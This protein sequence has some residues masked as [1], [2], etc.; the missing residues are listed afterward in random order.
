VK[1]LLVLAG[2]WRLEAGGWREEAERPEGGG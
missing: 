1:E 2:G